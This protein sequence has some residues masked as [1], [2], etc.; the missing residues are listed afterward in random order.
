M[1]LVLTISLALGVLAGCFSLTRATPTPAH[2]L[3]IEL[4]EV[5]AD[6]GQGYR[7]VVG[8][9][10]SVFLMASPLGSD[11]KVM[12]LDGEVSQSWQGVAPDGATIVEF[13]NTLEG[14]FALYSDGVLPIADDGTPG[15][16][17]LF[18]SSSYGDMRH[19]AINDNKV[20]ILARKTRAQASLLLFDMGDRTLSVVQEIDDQSRLGYAVVAVDD[21]FL[22]AW[23]TESPISGQFFDLEGSPVGAQIELWKR[24]KAMGYMLSAQPD[25][26]GGA[27]IAFM[28]SKLSYANPVAF[29]VSREREVSQPRRYSTSRDH[30]ST[31]LLASGGQGQIMFWG[32][33]GRASDYTARGALHMELV[34]VNEYPKYQRFAVNGPIS[35][36]SSAV[37]AGKLLV[38]GQ[39]WLR[40]DNGEYIGLRRLAGVFDRAQLAEGA[41]VSTHVAS[42]GGRDAQ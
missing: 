38:V 26:A 27:V 5:S 32:H 31:L 33:A 19:Y 7:F 30:G 11:V 9:T 8:A 16:Y 39:E 3:P 29:T 24:D 40:D 10:D 36:F 35:Q 2:S 17:I 20:M 15:E 28:E 12:N 4:G 25:G 21:G 41:S 37:C 22:L 1:N 14:T 34:D 23:S 13:I 18:N 6:V 42:E